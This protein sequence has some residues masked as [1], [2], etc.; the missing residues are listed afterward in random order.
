MDRNIPSEAQWMQ[1][2]SDNAKAALNDIC[3]IIADTIETAAVYCLGYRNTINTV[4]TGIFIENNQSEHIHFYLVVF[5]KKLQK[6]S[7]MKLNRQISKNIGSQAAVT[8][9]LHSTASLHE[10]T[11]S[12]HY[13]FYR[14]FEQ[15][16]IVYQ[17]QEI[18]SLLNV[19][20]EPKPSYDD[21][22]IYLYN[23]NAAAMDYLEALQA[24]EKNGSTTPSVI[25]LH[26]AVEHICLML[27]HSLL[28]YHPQKFHT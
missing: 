18:Q 4:S 10:V 8:L 22:R 24:I 16:N 14:L 20:D 23:R 19:V 12:Q 6:N 27:I 11:K 21:S 7:L 26:L 13:F 1:G 9:L 3:T 25:L 5:V 17:S 2:I 28:G 15:G